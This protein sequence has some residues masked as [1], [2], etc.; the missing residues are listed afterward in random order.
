MDA[1][2]VCGISNG[3]S[4]TTADDGVYVNEFPTIR[5][6]CEMFE[7]TWNADFISQLQRAVNSGCSVRFQFDFSV[8][9]VTMEGSSLEILK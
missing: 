2:T 1:N 9:V 5:C 4:G 6:S 7:Y 8:T 3:F